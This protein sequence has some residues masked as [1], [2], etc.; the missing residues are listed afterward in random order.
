MPSLVIARA[1]IVVVSGRLDHRGDDIKVVAREIKELEVRG[2]D[3]VRLEVP[4]AALSPRAVG[5]LKEILSNHPGTSPVFLHMVSNG[6]HKVLKLGD[7]TASNPAA[8]STPNSASSSVPERLSED[9][10]RQSADG[11]RRSAEEGGRA[12]TP[13]SPDE[14]A[15]PFFPSPGRGKGPLRSSG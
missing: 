9:G 11:R 14:E 10:R 8:P 3:E 5:R 15:A 1:P 6:N 7:S 4:A 2:A 13:P 12:F